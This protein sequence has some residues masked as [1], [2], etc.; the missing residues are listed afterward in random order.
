MVVQKRSAMVGVVVVLVLVLGNVMWEQRDWYLY[1]CNLVLLH[2]CTLV[3]LY[4]SLL[5]CYTAVGTYCCTALLF[6][7]VLL[8]GSREQVG[9]LYCNP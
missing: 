2:Y 3:L 1:S 5:Y 4:C 7:S 8:F 9:L 6:Y